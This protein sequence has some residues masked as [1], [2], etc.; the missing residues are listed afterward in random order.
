MKAGALALLIVF[1]PCAAAAQDPQPPPASQPDP[2]SQPPSAPGPLNPTQEIAK[3]APE[4][5]ALAIG[6]ARIRFGGYLGV[7][8]LFRSTNSGGAAATQFAT[9]PY[10]DTVEGN[11]SEARLTA[12]TSRLSIRVDAAPL[13]GHSELAGYFEMDF[14]GTRP[15]NVAVTTTSRSLPDSA[16]T[17]S[18]SRLIRR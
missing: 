3:E 6:P 1:A 16:P 15:G 12:E 11:V 4:G 13:P 2:A 8:G 7:I 5:P 14:A 10:P 9:T 18:M 17:S